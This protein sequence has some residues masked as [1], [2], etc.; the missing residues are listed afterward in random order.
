MRFNFG[1]GVGCR[2]F[3]PCAP[4]DKASCAGFAED[5]AVGFLLS[6]CP[7]VLNVFWRFSD[8]LINSLVVTNIEVVRVVYSADRLRWLDLSSQHYSAN[9]PSAWFVAAETFCKD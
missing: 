6:A 8:E 2:V 4:F 9:Y 5:G 1:S 3:S 7:N